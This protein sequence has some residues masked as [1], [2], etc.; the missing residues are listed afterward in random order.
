[1]RRCTLF[2]VFVVLL[3]ATYTRTMESQSERS[4]R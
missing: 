4:P 2:V 1:M 3:A